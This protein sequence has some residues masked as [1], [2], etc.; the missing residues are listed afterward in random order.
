MLRTL[1]H[2]VARQDEHL[3]IAAGQMFAHTPPVEFLNKDAIISKGP[4]HFASQTRKR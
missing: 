1:G 4:R 2:L 3:T